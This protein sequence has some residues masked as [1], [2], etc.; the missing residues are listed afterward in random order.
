MYS[1]FVLVDKLISSYTF[2]AEYDGDIAISLFINFLISWYYIHHFNIVFIILK[3]GM[4]KKYKLIKTNSVTSLLLS[5]AMSL[6]LHL[7]TYQLQITTS[8]TSKYV[9]YF[10]TEVLKMVYIDLLGSILTCSGSMST[11][12]KIGGSSCVNRVTPYR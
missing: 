12:K 4:T 9:N 5:N 6:V 10:K 3:P 2:V 7:T 1:I 8:L 11:K